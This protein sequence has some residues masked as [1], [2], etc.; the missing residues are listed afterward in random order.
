MTRV[1]LV[2]GA[3]SGIGE[4]IAV[5]LASQGIKTYGAARHPERMNALEEAGGHPI[6]LDLTDPASIDAGVSSIVAE[7]GAVDILVNAAGTALYGSVEEVPVDKARRLFEVN[8]FGGASLIHQLAALMRVRRS[9]TII[10]ITSVGGVVALPYG[11][12]YHASKFALEG[13]SAS[14]RQ[15]LNPFGV[16]VVI[17]RPEAIRTGWRA[18]VGETLLA[19]S[20]DGPYA[21]ATR[22]ANAKFTSPAFE[23][24]LCDPNVVAD[25]V[26]KILSARRPRTVYRVPRMA[27]VLLTMMALMGSDRLRDAFVRKF[28][29]LP[30]NM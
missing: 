23:D 5:R 24:R 7:H 3:S 17:I 1:A 10:N 15:E 20:G 2:T 19:H 25:V 13:F 8:L 30:K 27:S 18:I 29:G 11:A 26:D 12:W 9:G 6:L 16:D 22:A 21:T 28:I 14:L 4:A